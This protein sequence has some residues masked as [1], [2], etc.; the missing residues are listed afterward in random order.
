MQRWAL[1]TLFQKRK[2]ILTCKSAAQNAQLIFLISETQHYFRN[3]LFDLVEAQ[4]NSAVVQR[5]FR[6]K[7][8]YNLTSA[9]EI[10]Q[11]NAHTAFSAILD[12]KK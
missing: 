5:H 10:W 2:N 7:F 12:K 9:I 3:E 6:T 1:I 4:R 8:K 11:H